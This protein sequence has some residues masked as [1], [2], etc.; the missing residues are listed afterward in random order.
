MGC[1]G[2]VSNH[3]PAAWC[4]R[5]GDGE[6]SPCE[7]AGSTAA[8]GLTQPSAHFKKAKTLLED[9]KQ[10]WGE[11]GASVTEAVGTEQIRRQSSPSQRESQW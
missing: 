3:I 9:L 7:G 2:E 1:T 5:G 6:A 8:S 10:K 11:Q 4:H